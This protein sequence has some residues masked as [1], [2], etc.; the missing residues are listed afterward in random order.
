M[1]TKNKDQKAWLSTA[2]MVLSII[3]LVLCL[4]VI[5]AFLW[6]PLAL[7]WLIFGIIALVKKQKKGMAIAWVI[8]WWLVTLI[9]IAIVIF[10]TIFIKNNADV[11]LDP[12]MEMSEM[13]EN[14]PEL[15]DMM[16]DPIIQAE[17]EVL[18]KERLIERF[19][20]DFGENEKF[21]SRE[22]IKIQIPVIFDEMKVLML[23]LK[24]KHSEE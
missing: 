8:I 11:I 14:D 20:E 22:D 15:A 6:V 12:I 13:M 5:W 17:F 7:L 1:P 2:S 3:W 24:E 16:N 4:T 21:E 9:T 23:E 18:F 10:G 19:G